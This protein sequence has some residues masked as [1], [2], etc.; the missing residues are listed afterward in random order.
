MSAPAF[1]FPDGIDAGGKGTVQFVPAIADVSAPTLAEINAGFPMQ[2]AIYAWNMTG[3]QATRQ[4][5]RYCSTQ[6]IESLGQ[7]QITID[8]V[9]YVYDPQNPE[10]TTGPYAHY[11]KLAEG[12]TWFVVD[13][14]GLDQDE[15]FAAGQVV[16]VVKVTA[17]Y[18]NRVAITPGDDA[19]KLRVSQKF[20]V[21]SLV[22]QDV[23]I[24]G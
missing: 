22:S 2:C 24:A 10:E 4:E 21:T 19:G 13:R 12:T 17:G 18:R 1:E 6:A 15:P 11:G 9:E 16:D 3:E 20:A 7:T 14:R 8:P 5:L 23:E